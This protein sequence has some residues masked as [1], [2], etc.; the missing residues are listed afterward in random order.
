LFDPVL[1]N[2]FKGRQI[3]QRQ[4]KQQ[5]VTNVVCEES[6]KNDTSKVSSKMKSKPVESSSTEEHGNRKL[7]QTISKTKNETV[8]KKAGHEK[9][10]HTSSVQH[11]DKKKR[12]TINEAGISTIAKHKQEKP[13]KVLRE[14]ESDVECAPLTGKSERED[15]NKTTKRVHNIESE[16]DFSS[17]DSQLSSSSLP[18]SST[19]PKLKKP[20]W[21]RLYVLSSSE[22]ESSSDSK[23]DTCDFS[24]KTSLLLKQNK[25]HQA[26]QDITFNSQCSLSKSWSS[27]QQYSMNDNLDLN[28]NILDDRKKHNEEEDNDST[29]S[30]DLFSRATKIKK[31]IRKESVGMFSTLFQ[32]ILVDNYELFLF[33]RNLIP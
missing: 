23:G 19:Q 9:E 28:N 29:S 25:H 13:K 27:K 6:T 12:F 26:K 24:E 8:N 4:Q 31:H 2:D 11:G 10:L 15:V 17:E 20:A 32:L 3:S 30:V 1:S 22:E 5:N 18:Q 33:R 21:K 14:K 16:E 7:L